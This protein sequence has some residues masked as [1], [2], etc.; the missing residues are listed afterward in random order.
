MMPGNLFRLQLG[1]AF[2]NRRRVILRIG[3]SLLL[4]IPFIFVDM[5]PRA[6]ALGIVM[7]IMFTSF[8]GAAVSYA[9]LRTD[10]RLERLT[11]LPIS[12][13]EVYLD[14]IAAS[15]LSRLVPV[16]AIVTG[17]VVIKGQAVTPAVLIY[18]LAM[19]CSCLL[20]LTAL[21]IAVG[22]LAR[23]NGEVHLFGALA[24][25]SMAFISGMTPLPARLQWL[26]ST[27]GFNPISR[28]F[29]ALI[30]LNTGAKPVSETELFFASVFLVVITAIITLR[31]IL[32]GQ[33][34][35]KKFNTHNIAADN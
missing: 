27:M 11:L 13:A 6:Q 19:V 30:R 18:L 29:S 14:L 10:L 28:L 24:C 1:D 12:R 16:L 8:F 33:G 17:F 4:A 15:V 3:I 34:I 35:T 5:P 7:V 22:H 32:G 26:T 20:L 31:W 21:G 9:H 2:G 23:S 25:A